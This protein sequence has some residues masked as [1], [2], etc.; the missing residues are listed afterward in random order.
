MWITS[1]MVLIIGLINRL[2]PDVYGLDLIKASNGDLKRGTIYRD[3]SKMEEI[4][5]IKSR[6]EDE[7]QPGLSAKRKLFSL[8]DDVEKK[9]NIDLS[10]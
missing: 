4:G 10:E 1:K 3:L 5:L 9:I 7:I 2:G 8:C 6:K